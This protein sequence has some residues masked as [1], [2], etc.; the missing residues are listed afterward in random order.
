MRPSGPPL[1]GGPTARKASHSAAYTI[2]AA[3]EPP[4]AVP[5]RG[6]YS[7]HGTH[8]VLGEEDFSGPTVFALPLL[9]SVVNRH[10]DAGD[11]SCCRWRTGGWRRR[12]LVA[13][14][15]PQRL[16]GAWGG[17]RSSAAAAAARPRHPTRT[18]D[19]PTRLLAGLPPHSI[20]RG[21]FGR[22]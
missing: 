14:P 6:R 13:P 9:Q 20:F 3:G 19:D 15:P 4:D 8:R 21:S 1:S 12:V 5:V 17:A 11:F 7:E 16:S 22:D 18:V 10:R 2:M